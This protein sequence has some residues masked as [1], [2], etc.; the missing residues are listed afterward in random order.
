MSMY[1]MTKKLMSHTELER[2]CSHLRGGSFTVQQNSRWRCWDHHQWKN[3]CVSLKENISG[4]RSPA[5]KQLL[6]IRISIMEKK[7]ATVQEKYFVSDDIESAALN[8]KRR[9]L[10]G[11]LNGLRT[12]TAIFLTNPNTDCCL[13]FSTPI[14]G[15]IREYV[16]Y[17]ASKDIKQF[18]RAPATSKDHFIWRYSFCSYS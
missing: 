15:R 8:P 4:I 12:A 14:Q 1:F 6:Y 16:M 5:S 11:T 2:K 9:Q 17:S 7:L 10:P 18:L 3:S 13:F